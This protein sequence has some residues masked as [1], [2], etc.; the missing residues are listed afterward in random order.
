MGIKNRLKRYKLFNCEPGLFDNGSESALGDVF[1]GMIG[2]DCAPVGNRIIPNFMASFSVAV[3]D[4]SGFSKFMYNIRGLKRRQ[5]RH[6]STGTGIFRSNF[7]WAEGSN[8]MTL[9]RGSL[10]SMQDSIILRATSSAISKVSA[11][12]LPWAINPCRAELVAKYPPSSSGSIDRGIRH[13]DIFAFSLWK[14]DNIKV[15]LCQ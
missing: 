6:A 7:L 2:N 4:E 12:V 5:M 14:K 3:E 10:C 15:V 1:P 11:T 13:S 9:G 8:R